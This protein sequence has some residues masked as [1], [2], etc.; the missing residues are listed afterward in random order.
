MGFRVMDE[1]GNIMDAH[2]ED[3]ILT[4]VGQEEAVK[5]HETMV[6]VSVMDDILYEAQRHGQLSFYM[7]SDGEEATTVGSGSGLEA[8]DVV[9][10][11]YREQGILAY[12]CFTY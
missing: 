3:E 8:R 5:M 1:G 11:Q 4:N 7:T 10:A 2:E 6:R 12:R 9:F